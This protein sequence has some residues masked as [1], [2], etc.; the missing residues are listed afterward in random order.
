[1]VVGK[2]KE[3]FTPYVPMS[4]WLT[5]GRCA[6]ARASCGMGWWGPYS[7]SSRPAAATEERDGKGLALN[8]SLSIHFFDEKTK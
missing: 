4:A 3:C 6:S 8:N 2:A 5:G 7:A 1:M